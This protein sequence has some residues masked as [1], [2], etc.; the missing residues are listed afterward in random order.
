MIWLKSKWNSCRTL[1]LNNSLFTGPLEFEDP[2]KTK[3][4]Y[5]VREDP[6]SPVTISAEITGFPSARAFTLYKGNPDV[7]VTVSNSTYNIEFI[8]RSPSAGTAMVTLTIH[9]DSDLT[10]YTLVMGNGIGDDLHYVF[11]LKEGKFI[12]RPNPTSGLLCV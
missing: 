6:N 9:T 3:R 1:A 2:T 12:R 4:E 10:S 7:N 8:E 5:R 11:T